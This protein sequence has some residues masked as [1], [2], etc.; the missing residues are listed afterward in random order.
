MK[1]YRIA[2]RSDVESAWKWCSTI[3]V[4]RWTVFQFLQ[5][6]KALPQDRLR[7]FTASSQKDLDIQLA[8]ENQGLEAG[9]LTVAQFLHPPLSSPQEV[10]RSHSSPSV[11][12][13]TP[14]LPAP[15]MGCDL[16]DREYIEEERRRRE[17]EAGPGG[18]HDL[19]YT[20]DSPSSPQ[21]ALAWTRLLARVQ[22]G[23]LQP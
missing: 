15:L 12:S 22:D 13:D 18:D 21:Q 19:P 2:I 11:P 8:R 6:Y 1:Y 9:S 23:I 20:F 16:I 4:T 17:L 10:L 14:V 7:V 3:L 5:I